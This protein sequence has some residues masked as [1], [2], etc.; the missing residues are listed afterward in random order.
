MKNQWERR[1][2]E[3]REEKRERERERERNFILHC[4]DKK[5]YL[6]IDH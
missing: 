3:R 1:E 5:A 4:N 2:E 6:K